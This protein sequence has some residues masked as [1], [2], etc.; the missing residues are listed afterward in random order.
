MIIMRNTFYIFLLNIHS[1]FSPVVRTFNKIRI[2]A[3]PLQLDNEKAADNQILCSNTL[4]A[5]VIR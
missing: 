2:R 4:S 1:A 5:A 3:S